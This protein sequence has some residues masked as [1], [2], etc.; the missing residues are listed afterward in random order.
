MSV[1]IIV[2]ADDF[3]E[4]VRVMKSILYPDVPDDVSIKVAI[5]KDLQTVLSALCND[6]RTFIE[7]LDSYY[8]DEITERL[9]FLE[10]LNR[11]VREINVLDEYGSFLLTVE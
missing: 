10:K 4:L 11:S 1:E 9:R 3:D 8:L 6:D 2:R 5:C 7:E